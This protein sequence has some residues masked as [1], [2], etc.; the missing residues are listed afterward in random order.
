[1][2]ATVAENIQ[3]DERTKLPLYAIGVTTVINLLLALINIGSSVGFNAF[4]AL[5]VI[6]YYSSFILAASVMLHKRLTT[7]NS[8]LPWGPFKLGRAGVPVTIVAIVYSVVGAFFSVWPTTTKPDAEGMNWCIL[9]F[10]AVVLFSLLFWAFYG[11]K[12]YRGPVLVD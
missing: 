2:S 11:R 9:V 8:D 6:S 7:P 10:G 4:I 3:V 1:M 5:I 12:Y